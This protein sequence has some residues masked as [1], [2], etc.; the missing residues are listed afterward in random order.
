MLS[1][2]L[3]TASSSSATPMSSSSA[4]ISIFIFEFSAAMSLYCFK[5]SEIPQNWDEDNTTNW[6]DLIGED[7]KEIDDT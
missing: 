4:L 2:H 1:R 6:D 7:V 5:I 3:L